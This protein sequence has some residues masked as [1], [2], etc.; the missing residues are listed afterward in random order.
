LATSC[1]RPCV[2][3]AF[4]RLNR[5][6]YIGGCYVGSSGDAGNIQATCTQ[7]FAI[8]QSLFDITISGKTYSIKEQID[9]QAGTAGL[10][11]KKETG[12]ISGLPQ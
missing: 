1:Q 9:G 6:D 11:K 12:F 3:F 4:R 2:F 7:V 8:N 5:A 10:L